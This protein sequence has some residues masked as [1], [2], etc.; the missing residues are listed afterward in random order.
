MRH[1]QKLML[2]LVAGVLAVLLTSRPMWWGVLF[3]PVA[4]PLYC[5]QAEEDAPP[6]WHWEEDGIVLRFRSLDL[7]LAF[8]RGLGQ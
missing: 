7:L 8:L 6:C 4:Q 3:S 2:S 5:A 1:K